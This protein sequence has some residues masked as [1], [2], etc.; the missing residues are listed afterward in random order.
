[1]STPLILNEEKLDM[2]DLPGQQSVADLVVSCPVVRTEL[3][4]N[5][6]E[7]SVIGGDAVQSKSVGD[8]GS[9]FRSQH[10]ALIN[11][12]TRSEAKSPR[13][14]R[15]AACQCDPVVID[16]ELTASEASNKNDETERQMT[17]VRTCRHIPVIFDW[18]DGD[19]ETRGVALTDPGGGRDV[20]RSDVNARQSR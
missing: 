1:M 2:A 18:K 14:N 20:R 17:R 9:Q 13:A 16:G 7:L 10:E 8:F 15:K 19:V 5:D 4:E 11:T 6:A 3:N 12:S